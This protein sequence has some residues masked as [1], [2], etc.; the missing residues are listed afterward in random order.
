[1]TNQTKIEEAYVA[2]HARA[3]Q[4]AEAV[5]RM[6]EDQPAP[7]G[8]NRIGWDHVGTLRHYAEQLEDLLGTH[9]SEDAGN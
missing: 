1:M 9:E 4:A 3:L 7:N 2:A 6:I 8:D 5:R